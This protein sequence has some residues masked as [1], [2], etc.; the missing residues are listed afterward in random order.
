MPTFTWILSTYSKI[1]AVADN[2]FDARK[3]ALEQACYDEKDRFA[4]QNTT[5]EIDETY[6]YA[7]QIIND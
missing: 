5:P 3:A 4:V 1:I 2:L 6:P 7:E